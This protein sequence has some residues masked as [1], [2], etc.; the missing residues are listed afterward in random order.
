MK[1]RELI[2]SILFISL[3]IIMLIALTYIIRTNGDVKDRFVG[4]YAEKKNSIDTVIIGSSPVYPY[5]CAPKMYGDTGIV[6]YPISTN[7]QRPKAALSLI[8]E[9]EKTQKPQLYIFEMRM[10]TAADKDLTTNMAYTRGITD[11]LKYSLNR[12]Q[13]INRLVDD[14]SER[15][16]YYFDIFKYHSNWKT[17]FL[18]SQL[19]TMLY[20]YPDDL[21]GYVFND[22]LGPSDIADYSYITEKK[23]I[24]SDEED[25]LKELIQYLKSNNHQ[26]LFIVS[27]YTMTEE[28]QQMYNYMRDI[29]ESSG[30][31]LLNLND[32]YDEL[33]IDFQT[34][35]YD[36]GGHVNA[37][38][39]EKCTAFLEQYLLEHYNWTDKRDT[40]GYESW[41]KSYTL[42]QEQQDTAV[43]TIQK[44][45]EQKDYAVIEEE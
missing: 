30:F 17:F 25:V 6:M 9:I 13:T 37:L 43:K 3:A 26:A 4:F 19:R 29:I 42:W 10:Y 5:Y 24:P 27:P 33:Q 34:D 39:S 36:Y 20:E 7:L 41:D 23:P 38:G 18:P 21:K 28:K 45:I 11:N 32:Y 16:T 14:K 1:K 8:K 12:I 22:K 15:Y 44:R 35:Y 2:K 40:S 31:E